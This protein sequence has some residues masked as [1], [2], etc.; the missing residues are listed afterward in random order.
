[1]PATFRPIK[2]RIAGRDPGA[3]QCAE[4]LGDLA[5]GRLRPRIHE[6]A[7]AGDEAAHDGEPCGGL[8]RGRRS[9]GLIER[10]QYATTVG[11]LRGDRLRAAFPAGCAGLRRE[12]PPLRADAELVETRERARGGALAHFTD[13]PRTNL[14]EELTT[15]RAAGGG[16]PQEVALLGLRS[17]RC[18]PE[19]IAALTGHSCRPLEERRCQARIA[20][21]D[22]ARDPKPLA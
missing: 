20:G 12:R 7:T 17:R 11:I 6:Y 19:V 2:P 15:L 18:V 8:E 16:E 1:M 21:L 4:M 22:A 14:N 9:P 5:H 10:Y 3:E 13:A